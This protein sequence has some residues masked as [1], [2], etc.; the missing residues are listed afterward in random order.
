MK[1]LFDVRDNTTK[2]IVSEHGFDDK[3][4]AKA[5]RNQL[6][7]EHDSE[8]RFVVVIGPDHHKYNRSGM[9]DAQGNN[10]R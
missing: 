10:R 6:N 4:L 3:Q 7:E 9:N 2:R 1:R 5:Y 8:G